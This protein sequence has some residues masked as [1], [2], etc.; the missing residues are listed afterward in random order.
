MG[1]T[2]DDCYQKAGEICPGGYEIVD[3]ASGI[4]AVPVSGGV[5][6]APQHNLVIECR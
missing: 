2:L 4:V 3:R 6:A 1:R 5:I